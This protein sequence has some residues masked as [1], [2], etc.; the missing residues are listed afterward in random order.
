MRTQ[1]KVKLICNACGKVFYRYPSAIKTKNVYCS[2][3]CLQLTNRIDID[4]KII[5]DL[6]FNKKMS[7]E[8]VARKLKF[9]YG[10]VYNIFQRNHWK[11][12][13]KSEANSLAKSLKININ[14]LKNLYTIKKLSINKVARKLNVSYTAIKN[15]LIKNNIYIRSKSEA[16][17]GKQNHRYNSVNV[18]CAYCHKKLIRSQYFIKHRINHFCDY[19]CMGKW[20]SKYLIGKKSVAYIHGHGNLPY[21]NA[22]TDI[23]KEK[24]RQRDNYTCQ[25]CGC[26]EENHYRANKQINLTVHHIDYN[27]MNCKESNLITVCNCCNIQANANIDYWFAYYTYLMNKKHSEVK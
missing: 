1:N 2:L 9:S 21:S 24:I 19:K 17:Q 25:N 14:L 3:K 27:K 23:L 26:K 22:F 11:F 13:T 10:V 16:L 4:D 20:R 5:F 6:Y 8:S 7:K 12:R 15:H 18:K